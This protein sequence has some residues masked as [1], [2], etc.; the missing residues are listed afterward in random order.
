MA[1]KVSRADFMFFPPPPPQTILKFNSAN[2]QLA[3]TELHTSNLT[4][5]SVNR[6]D[7]HFESN[8][9]VQKYNI[10]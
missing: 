8:R 10:Y 3:Q 1:A 4:A 7:W 6:S 9:S 2:R 5:V